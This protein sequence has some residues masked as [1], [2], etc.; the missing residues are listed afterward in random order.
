VKPLLL[1]VR[2]AALALVAAGAYIGLAV[3]AHN[4]TALNSSVIDTVSASFLPANTAPVLAPIAN[5]MANV[6]SNVVVAISATDT[7]APPQTLA[8]SLATAPAGASLTQINNTNANISWRPAVTDANATNVFALKVADNGSPGL[9]A[10]QSFTVT[11]NPLA[12]PVVSFLAP[13]NIWV[14]LQVSGQAGPDYAVQISANL[15][16]WSP[17]FITNSPAMPFAW[18]DTNGATFSARFYRIKTG[19][20]L[21]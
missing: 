8:F 1:L 2:T 12:R 18:A 16:N 11:V 17:V 20:P 13:N 15:S 3:C 9:S 7:D 6:G 19:P 4:N 14:S 21:P 10:T 5:R